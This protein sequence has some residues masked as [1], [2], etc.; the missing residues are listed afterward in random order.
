MGELDECGVTNSE[1]VVPSKEGRI[2]IYT[3]DR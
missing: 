3:R 1:K 2:S